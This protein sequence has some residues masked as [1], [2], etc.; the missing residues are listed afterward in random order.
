MGVQHGEMGAY[1][2]LANVSNGLVQ[3]LDLLIREFIAVLLRMQFRM[4]QAFISDPV[5]YA[6]DGS[7]V[8]D[9][10]FDRNMA[11]S[12]NGLEV[13][14]AEFF[15]VDHGIGAILDQWRVLTNLGSRTVNEADA[16]KSSLVVRQK[17]SDYF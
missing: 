4:I 6:A 5:S 2:C 13:L 17:D 11:L 1:R 12:H 15:F 9:Q 3:P 10:S 8:E 16:A 14:F 7:L